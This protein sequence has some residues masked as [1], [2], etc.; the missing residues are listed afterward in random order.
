MLRFVT[1]RF[2]DSDKEFA[3]VHEGDEP[4]AVGQRV[5]VPGRGGD[6][7]VRVVRVSTERPPRVPANTRFVPI[8]RV[9][10]AEAAPGAAP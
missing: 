4:I 2:P 6:V 10:P 3:Y 9:W 5:D 1:I 8:K 7:T